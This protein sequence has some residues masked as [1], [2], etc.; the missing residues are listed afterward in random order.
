MTVEDLKKYKDTLYSAISRDLSEF[1]KNF[2]FISTGILAFTITFLKDAIDLEESTYLILLLLS[3]FLIILSIAL[4]MFT[5]LISARASD[6]LFKIVD[7]FIIE[8]NLF[9]NNDKL[10]P[11]KNQEIKS[12]TNKRFYAEKTK[13]RCLR[14][15]AVISFIIG[16]IILS[17]FVYV[18]LTNITA[19]NN[20]QTASLITCSF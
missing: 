5:F 15:W 16:L 20:P 18:N 11:E 17:L 2:I 14:S 7:D 8:N 12:K 19:I 1:E 6:R 9:E 10:T 13:L 4:M 3:W